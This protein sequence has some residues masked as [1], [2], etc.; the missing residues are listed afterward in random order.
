MIER[1][2]VR[3]YR[4]FQELQLALASSAT[5]KH[6]RLNHLE[7]EVN[8]VI[9]MMNQLHGRAKLIPRMVQVL[10]TRQGKQLQPMA[11]AATAALTRSGGTEPDTPP[12]AGIRAELGAV[13]EE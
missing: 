5:G 10:S 6:A 8:R 1:V 4:L 12:G 9:M 11:P 7:E 3:L 2:Q 13:P